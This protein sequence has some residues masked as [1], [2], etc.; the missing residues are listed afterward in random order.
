MSTRKK[1]DS[2]VVKFSVGEVELAAAN[3]L[4]EAGEI[5]A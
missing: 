1:T 5:P 2:S 4:R 3:A